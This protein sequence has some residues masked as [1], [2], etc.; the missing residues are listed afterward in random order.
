[1]PPADLAH[2]RSA[3]PP[4]EGG[5][6]PSA[7]ANAAKAALALALFALAA[8]IIL[9]RW[10]RVRVDWY[11]GSLRQDLGDEDARRG[12]A[13]MGDAAVP[14]LARELQSPDAN[15]RV[16]AVFALAS[17]ETPAA[18]ALLASAVEDPDPLA[19]ANA[20]AALA[21]RPGPEVLATIAGR[22][23]DARPPVRLAAR[24]SLATRSRLPWWTF[25]RPL[26]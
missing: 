18:S 6:A 12:L 13:S 22:L 19:A 17:V 21:R 7:A 1:M 25:G 26:A 15:M 14:H 8:W 11:L 2:G 9:S 10:D 20:V 24:R 3:A 5:R 4:P 23:A 16:L